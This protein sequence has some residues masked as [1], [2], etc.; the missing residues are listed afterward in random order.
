MGEGPLLH[1]PQTPPLPTHISVA[2][3]QP[4]LCWTLT[5]QHGISAFSKSGNADQFPEPCLSSALHFPENQK[6]RA[7]A[8]AP[9]TVVALARSCTLRLSQTKTACQPLAFG[10]SEFCSWAPLII[11]QGGVS[12]S[13]RKVSDLKG[14]LPQESWLGL[15]PSCMV[16]SLEWDWPLQAMLGPLQ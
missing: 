11:S 5:L 13:D 3:L 12:L 8:S 4:F 14:V 7:G 15:S 6:L 1:I 9:V 2:S 16:R 10:H